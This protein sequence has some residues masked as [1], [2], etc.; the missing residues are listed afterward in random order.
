M[1]NDHMTALEQALSALE[2]RQ[3]ETQKQ[4]EQLTSGFQ[5]LQQ[6]LLQQQS[7]STSALLLLPNNPTTTPPISLKLAARPIGPALPNEF[8]GDCSKG[9]T[10]IWLCQTY[11]VLCLESFSDDQTKIIWA[12]SYM[13]ARRAAKWAA[14]VFKWE[15]ENKGYTKFLDW[16]NFKTEFHK[17]FCPANSNIAAINKL[18]S[19]AYYQKT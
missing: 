8:N 19:M 13:K 3:I 12:L 4:L 2:A 14:W 15:E 17:E 1:S 5:Q 10:F 7:N 11:I 9:A 18:E 6:L 16:D